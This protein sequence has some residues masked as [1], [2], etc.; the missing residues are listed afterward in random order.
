MKYVGEL[1]GFM[2]AYP[3]R[4]FRMSELVR[5]VSRAGSLTLKQRRAMRKAVLRAIEALIGTGTVLRRPATAKR[6]GY[7]KYRWRGEND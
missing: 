5:H 3:G 6:G 4:E 1:I 7:A 2:G